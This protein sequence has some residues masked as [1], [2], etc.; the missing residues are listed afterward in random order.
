MTLQKIS[1]LALGLASLLEV[2][3]GIF[4]ALVN[5]CVRRSL[6]VLADARRVGGYD[7]AEVKVVFG[8]IGHGWDVVGLAGAA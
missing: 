7:A 5:N 6:R 4:L 2:R 1:M 3:R 8:E